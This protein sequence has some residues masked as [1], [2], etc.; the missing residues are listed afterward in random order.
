MIMTFFSFIGY[1]FQL[2][3]TSLIALSTLFKF[4]WNYK[5]FFVRVQKTNS[6]K[7]KILF[8]RLFSRISGTPRKGLFGYP[9]QHCE[10]LVFSTTCHSSTDSNPKVP[11]RTLLSIVFLEQKLVSCCEHANSILILLIS[12][13]GMSHMSE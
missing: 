8:S 4:Q 9:Q 13:C 6:R 5:F 2:P 12:K 3:F 7:M 10:S 1:P 11:S